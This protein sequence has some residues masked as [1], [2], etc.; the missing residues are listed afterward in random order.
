MKSPHAP[1]SRYQT[2][3]EINPIAPAATMTTHVG[4]RPATLRP[5]RQTSQS[6]TTDPAKAVVRRVCTASPANTPQAIAET[7]RRRS[8]DQQASVAPTQTISDSRATV[9]FRAYSTP[10]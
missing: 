1:R 7:R 3:A 4:N 2:G 5:R 10:A 6:M 9:M 8:V